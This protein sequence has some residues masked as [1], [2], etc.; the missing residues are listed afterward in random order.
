MTEH[1]FDAEERVGLTRFGFTIE[2]DGATA[3]LSPREFTLE[4]TGNMELIIT[5]PNGDHIF[6]GFHSMTGTVDGIKHCGEIPAADEMDAEKAAG[7]VELGFVAVD[8]VNGFRWPEG[9][10]AVAMRIEKKHSC[11]FDVTINFP[12]NGNKLYVKCDF[13]VGAIGGIE[14][15]DSNQRDDW[16]MP[17]SPLLTDCA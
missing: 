5:H 3:T 6:L 12:K 1:L 9:T 14:W 11:H 2:P 13:L 8:D 7:L 10:V 16:G 17:P 15:N 4:T